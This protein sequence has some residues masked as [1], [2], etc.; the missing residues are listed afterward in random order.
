MQDV[1]DAE[2]QRIHGEKEQEISRICVTLIAKQMFADGVLVSAGSLT[3]FQKLFNKVEDVAARDGL[4]ISY[5]KTELV[6]YNLKT[7]TKHNKEFE[8]RKTYKLDGKK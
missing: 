2:V 8:E 4:D 3:T 6:V 7:T 5:K 1:V